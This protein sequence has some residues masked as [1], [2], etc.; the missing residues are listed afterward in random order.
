MHRFI[1][2]WRINSGHASFL[3]LACLLIFIW[4]AFGLDPPKEPTPVDDQTTDALKL[5]QERVRDR[6][7]NPD[8]L[9][10]KVLAFRQTHLGS[11]QAIQAAGLLEQMPSPLDS[12]DPTGIPVLERYDWQP[13]E[14]VAVL[15][16][17]RGRHGGVAECVAFTPDGKTIISGGNNALLRLW[18][19]GTMRLR[20]RLQHSHYVHALQVSRDGKTLACGG[21]DGLVRLWDLAGPEPKERTV[22]RTGA[23]SPI[24]GLAISPNGKRLAWNAEGGSIR[25]WDIGL[26]EPKEIAVLGGHKE[27]VHCLAFSPDGRILVSGS[28]DHTVRL[29]DMTKAAPK[30]RHTIPGHN[31]EV[32]ALAFSPDGKLLASADLEGI[33]WVWSLTGATPKQKAV[34]KGPAIYSVAF[35]PNGKMLAAGRSDGSIELYDVSGSGIRERT[36][37][38]RHMY[39]VDALAFAPDSKALVSGSGDCTVRYWTL[40]GQQPIER[41]VTKGHLCHAYGLAIAP[42]AKTLASGG[43]H[44]TLHLWDLTGSELKER[45]SLKTS[46]G[47]IYSVDFSADGKFFV[48]SH[49]DTTVRLWQLAATREI[50][51]FKGHKDRVWCAK[52]LPN[53][54]QIVSASA[55]LRS[56]G[57][58]WIESEASSL[59]L[60]D[61]ASGQEVRQFAA[62]KEPVRTLDVAPDGTRVV[63]GSIHEE[64]RMGSYIPIDCSVRIWDL[65]GGEELLRME[66]HVR[67][68]YSVAYAVDGK[69]IWSSS[70]DAVVRRWQPGQGEPAVLP[71]V[72]EYVISLAA[73]PNGKMMAGLGYNGKLIL[74]EVDTGKKIR[75][76]QL[77]ELALAVTFASDS[78]HLALTLVGGPIYILRLAAPPTSTAAR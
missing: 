58:Y 30:T 43:E 20:S 62:F 25:L 48:T 63:T 74:W 22:L 54:K 6:K 35:A 40:T 12:L 10:Q 67:P 73:S 7:E 66:K 18:E 61:V 26:K 39:H 5:L 33:L 75:E 15:G 2:S 8:R 72:T 13:K 24:Y 68:V 52:F 49:S 56:D 17:H 44:A 46:A 38:R 16:E 78:R 34:F 11:P 37:L 23:A 53:G 28:K 65:A 32:K 50:K 55:K 70:L 19:P 77:R 47:A 29:W 31:A 51:Q 71:G 42:D 41:T 1:R 27:G 21:E 64:L 14:L 59:R 9:R 69:S 3:A 57:N 60:W 76:W 45:S 36:V 4:S